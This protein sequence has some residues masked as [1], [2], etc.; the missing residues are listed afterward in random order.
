MSGYRD[1]FRRPAMARLLASAGLGRVGNQMQTLVFVLLAVTRYH[2]AGSAG[3]IAMLAVL[4]GAALSPLAGTVLDRLDPSRCVIT[5]YWLTAALLA[6]MAVLAARD[7]LGFPVLAVLVAV[8]ALTTPLSQAGTRALIPAVVPE[9]LWDRANALD[10]IT[11]ELSYVA[12]PPAAGACFALAGPAATL[13]A[14]AATF[15]VAGLPLTGLATPRRP[16]AQRVPAPWS[17]IRYVLAEPALRGSALT[18]LTAR[19]G[20]GALTV[21]LPILALHHLHTGTSAVGLLWAAAAVAATASHALFGRVDTTHSERRW[22]CLGLGWAGLGLLV[23]ASAGSFPQAFAGMI[24]LGSAQGPIDVTTLSLTQRHTEP[25]W[26]G[27]SFSITLT[28]A[29]LGLPIGALM[30]GALAG[31]AGTSSAA[32]AGALMLSAAILARLAIP[33]AHPHGLPRGAG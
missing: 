23:L 2:S 33:A 21:A 1:L 20:F 8:S 3:V 25:A 5:D 28:L 31:T 13:A 24:V 22:I 12:G 9:N 30:G 4:P 10:S 6:V 16:T 26:L 11:V 29:T 7:A 32:A 15:C 19:T 14:T 18:M 27:R 17:G